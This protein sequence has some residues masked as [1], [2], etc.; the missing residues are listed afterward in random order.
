M[1][2]PGP[3]DSSV[4]MLLSFDGAMEDQ[5]VNASLGRLDYGF[6]AVHE[7]EQHAHFAMIPI[8]KCS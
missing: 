3:R 8:S 6:G 5:S 2:N 7:V 4:L 1:R